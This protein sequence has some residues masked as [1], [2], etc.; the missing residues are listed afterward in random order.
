[1]EHSQAVSNTKKNNV[2]KHEFPAIPVKRS[3]IWLEMIEL[4][5]QSLSDSSD[6]DQEMESGEYSEIIGYEEVNDPNTK[7]ILQWNQAIKESDRTP[8]TTHTQEWQ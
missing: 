8:T 4:V 1:M 2:I 5:Y 6:S 7:C 3:T